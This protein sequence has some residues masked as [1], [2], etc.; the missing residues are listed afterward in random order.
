MKSAVLACR[1]LLRQ[2]NTGRTPL[3][4]IKVATKLYVFTVLNIPS[5]SGS[6]VSSWICSSV[7]ISGLMEHLIAFTDLSCASQRVSLGL[8]I[9][10]W[11]WLTRAC[12][13][14]SAENFLGEKWNIFQTDTSVAKTFFRIDRHLA[15]EMQQS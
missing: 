13:S 4:I 12:I 7:S 3:S 9:L 6:P 2:V 15:A 14:F 1:A 10:S 11:G 8:I 5:A